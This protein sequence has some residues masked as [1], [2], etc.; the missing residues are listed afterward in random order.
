MLRPLCESLRVAARWRRRDIAGSE[1]IGSENGLACSGGCG[2]DFAVCLPEQLLS[3]GSMAGHIPVVGVLGCVQGFERLMNGL[4][5]CP[6][7]RVAS[8]ILTNRDTAS[9]NGQAE[10]SS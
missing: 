1:Y 7:V 5:G 4:I 3:V 8:P 10:E 9:E 6:E 2:A